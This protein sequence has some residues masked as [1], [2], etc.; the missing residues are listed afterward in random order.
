MVRACLPKLQRRRGRPLGMGHYVED[1]ILNS[2]P[3]SQRMEIVTPLEKG[4]R[5][6]IFM[7]R[8]CP[9]KLQR[10]RGCRPGVRY[11]VFDG[12]SFNPFFVE[13]PCPVFSHFVSC[14]STSHIPVQKGCLMWFLDAKVTECLCD[15]QLEEPLPAGNRTSWTIIVHSKCQR[16]RI[17]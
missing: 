7:V 13:I 4:G 14:A 8:A 16:N 2:L 1:S 11:Y 5:G 12:G 17:S 10:R 6:G 3:A 9:P 15:C